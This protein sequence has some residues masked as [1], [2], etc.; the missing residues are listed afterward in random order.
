MI[1][2]TAP[3]GRVARIPLGISNAQSYQKIAD[4]LQRSP[5]EMVFISDVAAELD[6]AQLAGMNIFPA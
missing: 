2:T 6:A 5:A 4:A 3:A 1:L